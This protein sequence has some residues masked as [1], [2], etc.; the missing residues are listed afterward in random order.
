MAIDNPPRLVIIDD[1]QITCK[2]LKTALSKKGYEVYTFTK[3]LPGLSFI[4]ENFC[5]L[6]ISDIRLPDIDGLML[7]D[8]LHKICSALPVIL[9]TGYASIPGAVEATKKGAYYY[10]PKPFNLKDLYALIEK[11]LKESEGLEIC[12]ERLKIKQ[13]RCFAGL[14]GE[15]PAMKNLFDK[16][17]KIAPLDCNVLIEG[18]SGTGKE[19]IAQAIHYLSPRK[20][21]PFVAFNC[22]AFSEDLAA[23]ELFGHEKEAF[24]GAVSKRIGLLE[25]AN[26]GTLFLDEVGECPLSLQ[27]KLLRVL[28]ERQFYRLGGT[29]PVDINIRIIAATNRNL[30]KM[31]ENSQFREDLFFRLNVVNIKVPPLRERKEDIPALVIHF[32]DK[33]NQKFKKDVQKVSP[34]FIKILLNYS[35]PGNVR[36]LENII[37]QA[38]ALCDKKT[39]EVDELPPDLKLIGKSQPE[40]QFLPLKEYERQYIRS[41][42]YL[43]GFNQK[44]AAKILGISR[45]TLWRKMKEFN[46]P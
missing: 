11:A 40:I 41:I 30:R 24:T 37:E 19:L 14:I 21:N 23:N 22:G 1:D 31:V 35:F 6:V 36:E 42:L 15:S 8:E 5:N 46:M 39:L 45:T 26:E 18:E 29:K 12:E 10:L 25:A 17:L 33:Y 32:L 2:R 16:I 9:I 43:T 20:D 28:Q 38:V 7:L 3:G 27:V 44:E 4:E 13:R 34:D